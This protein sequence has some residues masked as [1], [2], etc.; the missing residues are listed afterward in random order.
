MTALTD[1]QKERL[2]ESAR[3]AGEHGDSMLRSF[4][5]AD[6][7]DSEMY[8][9]ARRVYVAVS[10][11]TALE[12]AL[13]IEERRWRAYAAEQ[14]AKVAAAP[15]IKRGPS[16]GQS[17][18]SYRWVDPEKFTHYSGHIRIMVGLSLNGQGAK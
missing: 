2:Y 10:L 15:K 18:I 6:Q 9:G 14:A 12:T 11:G 3:T 13:A 16:A 5:G 4:S 1:A 8:F 7:A 17:A